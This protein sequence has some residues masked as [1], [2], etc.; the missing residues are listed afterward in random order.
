[1]STYIYKADIISFQLKKTD[2]KNLSACLRTSVSK[3]LI[4][5]HKNWKNAILSYIFFR[6]FD[7][8]VCERV[9]SLIQILETSKRMGHTH[10]L[11]AR[12]IRVRDSSPVIES[13]F[14]HEFGNSQKTL[15]FK[16]KKSLTLV[17]VVSAQHPPATI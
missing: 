1:M 11:N 9:K 2:R 16:L 8:L 7:E 3:F 4:V 10:V 6:I 14:E 15:F 5:S 13:A 17:P 12:I